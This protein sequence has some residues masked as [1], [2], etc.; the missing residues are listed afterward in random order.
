MG[1]GCRPAPLMTSRRCRA[2]CSRRGSSVTFSRLPS[3]PQ[4]LLFPCIH[5]RPSSTMKIMRPDTNGGCTWDFHAVS[6]V[7][8]TPASLKALSITA[9]ESHMNPARL[10]LR[11]GELLTTHTP[12]PRLQPSGGASRWTPTSQNRGLPSLIGPEVQ[13]GSF[14]AMALVHLGEQLRGSDLRPHLLLCACTPKFRRTLQG[15]LYWEKRPLARVF[16]VT[17]HPGFEAC[18]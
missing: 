9:L 7:G 17:A 10:G 1:V 18:R 12:G 6:P 13:F 3:T 11:G 8:C 2:C 4:E 5:D 14:S 15:K 16:S